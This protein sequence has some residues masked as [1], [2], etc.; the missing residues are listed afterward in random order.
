V[1][2][3]TRLVQHGDTLWDLAAAELGP[4][5]TDSD[6]AA[7]WPEWY[8]ANRALIG[9]DPDLLTPGQVLRIPAPGH[10]VPPTHQEK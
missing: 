1:R 3:A 7:R 10:P 2:T 6:I 4:E 9:P 8:A 5:A